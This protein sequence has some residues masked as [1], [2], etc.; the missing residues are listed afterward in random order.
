MSKLVFL[1]SLKKI[2]YKKVGFMCGLEIH[3]QLNT[4]KL[5]CSCP[6][7][8]VNNDSLKKN[9]E[10][11]IRFSLS[12]DGAVDEAAINEFRKGKY[13]IY[14]YNNEVSCLVDL[15]E[16]PPKGPNRKALSVAL[17]ISE[18]MELKLFDKVTFMRKLIVDGSITSGYQRTAMLGFGGVIETSFGKIKINGI[19]LEE[20]SCRTLERFDNHTIFA[21]DRQGIP[22]IEITTGP[23]V[24]TAKQGYELAKIIGNYLRSFPETKRGLGTI[25][26]DLN[27][28][29][30]GGTRVEIKG[31]QNLKLIPQIIDAEI[32]RQKIHL[33]IVDELKDRGVNEDNFS[34]KNIY[35]ITNIFKDTDS[36][37]VKENLSGKKSAVL[38]IKLSKFKGIL[39]HE[40][41]KNYRFA[42][43]I[44][45]KNKSHFP[46]IKGLFHS[47]ELPK[48]GITEMEV[49]DVREKLNL[50]DED[51]FILVVNDR[52]IATE[53]LNYILEIISELIKGPVEEVRQVDSKGDVTKPLRPMP[54]SA[55]M[56][57]ETDVKEVVLTKEMVEGEG[58]NIPELYD[59]KINRLNKEFNLDDNKIEV[60]L[61]NLGED[62][63]RELLKT[64]IK[65]G[66]VFSIVFELGKEVKKREKIELI[67]F[68]FDL[69]KEILRV[70]N[71]GKI[72]KNSLYNLYVNL[73]KE[74]KTN[75]DDLGKYLE[76]KGLI[77]EKVD[78]G[79][80]EKKI[81]EIINKNNGAPFGALMGISMKEFGGK[82]PGNII[83]KLLKKNLISDLI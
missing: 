23:D 50:E 75:L 28:S 48:Y 76:E 20:D 78:E 7:E 71:E 83:S 32:R 29:I 64:K 22:L 11:R 6:C 51:G 33:S 9:V 13:N 8:I 5:F 72:D 14:K 40:L 82:V 65:S 49:R 54:G 21:L 52:N 12:E 24:K 77:L 4:H 3:Q 79:E 57:P 30:K 45:N 60:I 38:A 18:M 15:D 1:D 2:D 56:Y 74:N 10:R 61:N 80:I 42:T 26:Q 25:R 67:E 53:S 43:E 68:E 47:D 46:S 17:R 19:N 36:A 69:I 81:I 63:F 55:R 70:L 66:Q 58:K 41:N 39:G 35:D 16:E 27:V 62:K 59:K 37:V 73:Y 31:T 34:D 44:S